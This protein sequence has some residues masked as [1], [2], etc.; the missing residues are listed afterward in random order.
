MLAAES[1]RLS[2]NDFGPLFASDETRLRVPIYNS[3]QPLDEISDLDLRHPLASLGAWYEQPGDLRA[4]LEHTLKPIARPQ[5]WATFEAV[6]RSLEQAWATFI[7]DA[8]KG[9]LGADVIP[10]LCAYEALLARALSS[11]QTGNEVGASY[12]LINQ[13]WVIGP[14]SFTTWAIIPLLHPLKLL[15]WRE[16]ARYFDS[17]VARLLD[18]A[19]PASIVDVKRFQQEL[20]ATYG[21]SGFPAALAL[22]PTP[23]R[24][25]ARF[26][27]V[28]EAEGYEL[29]FHEAAGAQA[30]GLDTDLLADDENELAA[31]RA[32]E[33]IV[34]VV[35]DYVETYPF[36]RDGV[37]IFLFECRN[38]ALPGL[39]IE[40]LTKVGQRRGWAIR[41]TVVV[42]TRERGAPLFRR[43]SKWTAGG[44]PGAERQGQAY[45]PPITVKVLECEPEELFS[46]HEDTDIVVL[47]DVLGERGQQ[48]RSELELLE[49]DDAPIEGYLPTYRARQEPFQRGEQYRR[50]L[51]TAPQQPAVARMFLL[52]QH[53]A[54]ERR[55]PRPGLEH[56]DLRLAD[57][58]EIA[59]KPGRVGVVPAGDRNLVPSAAHVERG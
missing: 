6:L 23:N 3:C 51:L 29:Y 5:V 33:G 9:L 15:W 54:I 49:G 26:L 34:A 30:F 47:A 58:R 4:D 11:F 43:V 55:A 10:L 59:A 7:I 56:P 44:H 38:G 14:P 41:L 16:R 19:A 2:S 53:A 25:A 24:P 46:Q 36:V 18:P 39:L 50:I 48:V 45:F 57:R 17:L 20:A 40:Q 21:S 28:E 8:R 27:P 31:L 22:P 13:A 37:E 35:Q 1:A 42:H 52:A 32:V 12:R